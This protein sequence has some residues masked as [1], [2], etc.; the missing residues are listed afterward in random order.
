MNPEPT[1]ISKAD[2]P[3]YRSADSARRMLSSDGKYNS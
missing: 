2:V 1:P 3:L